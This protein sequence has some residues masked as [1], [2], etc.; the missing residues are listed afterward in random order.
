M[1]V[2]NLRYQSD[3]CVNFVVVFCSN[4]PPVLAAAV[5]RAVADRILSENMDTY[6]EE[7]LVE[8]PQWE[9]E[10]PVADEQC[11]LSGYGNIPLTRKGDTSDR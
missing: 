4:A 8:Q 1:T 3:P 11:K 10:E 5:A 6:L 2:Y 7:K 9:G